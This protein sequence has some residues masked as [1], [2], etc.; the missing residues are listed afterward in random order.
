MHITCNNIH[1]YITFTILEGVLLAE[2]LQKTNTALKTHGMHK[3]RGQAYVYVERLL[4]Y[5]DSTPYF[6][7]LYL[8]MSLGSQP[9]D[10]RRRNKRGIARELFFSVEKDPC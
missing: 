4:S 6:S 10:Y 5:V 2:S 9:L 8:N 7:S 1:T 3:V